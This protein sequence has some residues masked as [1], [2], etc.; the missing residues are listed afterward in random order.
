MATV[1]ISGRQNTKMK[2]MKKYENRSENEVSTQNIQCIIFTRSMENVAKHFIWF[3][4]TSCMHETLNMNLGWKPNEKNRRPYLLWTTF[5]WI[6]LLVSLPSSRAVQICLA[7]FEV[8]GDV[9]VSNFPNT[10]YYPISR[11]I[12][13]LKLLGNMSL[14]STIAQCRTS[15]PTSILSIERS[16][17]NG[18]NID[19]N[20]R[21]E[22]I[23][24]QL[25]ALGK[26]NELSIRN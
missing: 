6:L 5:Y 14:L 10:Q 18:T 22:Y 12:F 23:K 13:S 21:N 8:V 4:G 20:M 15:H 3:D 25:R 19:N 2:Q 1:S 7:F 17:P 9:F 11:T 26:W 24:P 16:F